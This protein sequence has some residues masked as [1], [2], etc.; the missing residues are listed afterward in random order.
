VE[1]G[2]VLRPRHTPG[3]LVERGEIEVDRAPVQVS[4]LGARD[5]EVATQLGE[6]HDP[7]LVGSQPVTGRL[8][9]GDPP[10]VDGRMPPP[11]RPRNIHQSAGGQRGHE[12]LRDLFVQRA[13]PGVADR[14]LT[15]KEM[16]H[17]YRPLKLPMPSDPPE[18]VGAASPEDA[19]AASRP[20][21]GA[22]VNKYVRR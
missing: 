9:R 3:G 6:R 1:H 19:T 14:S 10:D 21:I 5:H 15:A 2:H 22:E 7:T 13:P 20:T 17:R 8:D 18:S 16:V 11:E 4:Q 12:A